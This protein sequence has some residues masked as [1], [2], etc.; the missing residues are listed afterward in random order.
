MFDVARALDDGSRQVGT[1]V[2]RLDKRLLVRTGQFVG[3]PIDEDRVA[4]V[5]RDPGVGAKLLWRD[6]A[7][8]APFCK[9]VGLAIGERVDGVPE[10]PLPQKIAW[11][12]RPASVSPTKVSVSGQSATVRVTRNEVGRAIGRRGSNVSLASRLVSIR[13]KVISEE[14]H[15]HA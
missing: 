6:D 10:G 5:V 2:E 8:D 13:I 9:Q 15:A 7:D 3:A 14:S 12:L 1:V 4:R 11:A